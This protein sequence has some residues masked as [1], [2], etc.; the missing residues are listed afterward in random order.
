MIY[1]LHSSLHNLIDNFD[2]EQEKQKL[3]T[4]AVLKKRKQ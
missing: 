3:L 1:F 4:K 2:L